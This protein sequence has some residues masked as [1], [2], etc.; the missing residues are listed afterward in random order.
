MQC[1]KGV[2]CA[3]HHSCADPGQ[4]AALHYRKEQGCV[5]GLACRLP[6]GLSGSPSSVHPGPPRH[7]RGALR[8]RADAEGG[9]SGPLLT[10]RAAQRLRTWL[11]APPPT[12]RG[13]RLMLLA[14]QGPPQH[15]WERT[16]P[17]LQL[18]RASAC[19]V[20][21]RPPMQAVVLQGRR[22]AGARAPGLT[23]QQQRQMTCRSIRW[24]SDRWLLKW[25]ASPLAQTCRSARHAALLYLLKSECL[26]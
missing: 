22:C 14:L 4:R 26:S 25:G 23:L 19:S 12:P 9:S 16:A 13:M 11:Q 7:E 21:G 18:Q 10:W 6:P 1:L 17:G 8:M 20:S 24:G 15:S 2:G 3:L 5:L